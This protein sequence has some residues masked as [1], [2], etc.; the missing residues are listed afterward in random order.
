MGSCAN[1]DAPFM[2]CGGIKREWSAAADKGQMIGPR[3]FRIGSFP[4]E[5]EG[6]ANRGLDAYLT[7]STP[8]LARDLLGRV[9]ERQ[10]DF[11]KIYN[12]VPRDVYFA[13]MN[14]ANARGIE[15]SGHLPFAIGLDEAVAAGQRSVEHA[16]ALPIACSNAGR[17]LRERGPGTKPIE[18]LR[19]AVMSPQ[20]EQCKQLLKAMATRG[21]W[22]VPTHVTRRFEANA[23]DPVFLEDERLRYIALPWR[24]VWW[25]DARRMQR[26][27]AEAGDPQLLRKFH[28][29]GLALTGEAHRAGVPI[30]AGTDAPDAYAFPGSGLHDELQELVRAG[31]S[32]AD[33]LRSA[34]LLPAKYAGRERES[35][36][37]DAGKLADLV[38][39]SGDPLRDIGNTRKIEMVVMGGRIYERAHLNQMLDFVE[40]KASSVAVFCRTT[41]RLLRSQEFRNMFDD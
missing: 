6:H 28:Q 34:T 9:G 37:I 18:I 8:A 36:S 2:S 11:V 14:E 16:T 21:T 31:M 27:V 40:R 22:Y 23:D 29:R 24:I 4:I 38:L 7:P 15:V 32:P 19:E 26:R 13:L 30:L 10:W 41:W 12:R 20:D 1:E 35:G 25:L 17:T 33:A 5:I 3:I 39:L